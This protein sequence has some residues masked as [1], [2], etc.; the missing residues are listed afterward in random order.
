[1]F[2]RHWFRQTQ[3]GNMYIYV[4]VC[5]CMCIY[6]YCLYA[7][8]LHN[9]IP[10][11]ILPSSETVTCYVKWKNVKEIQMCVCVNTHTHTYIWYIHTLSGSLSERKISRKR[12]A[13]T[14][15]GTKIFI[16]QTGVNRKL[17]SGSCWSETT[18]WSNWQC[19]GGKTHHSPGGKEQGVLE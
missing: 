13:V 18:I 6:I 19:T 9:L 10:I 4:Y 8:L 2:S 11:L 14:W 17:A 3:A 7:C 12:T 15:N 5:M 16:E 1:M